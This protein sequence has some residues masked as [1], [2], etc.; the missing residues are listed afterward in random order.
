MKMK[1]ALIWILLIFI[2]VA[3][4]SC[5]SYPEAEQLLAAK[6]DSLPEIVDYNLHVRPILSDKCFN[7][8]GP[9][10]NKQEGGLALHIFELATKEIK[11]HKAISPGNLVQSEAIKRILSNDSEL[12]MPLSGSNLSLTDLE[13]ATLI[14]WIDQGAKY[15]PHWAFI[16][17]LPIS[18]PEVKNKSWVINPIDNFIL[19]KLEKELIQPS[20]QANKEKLA[21]RVS[22]DITGLP[23]TI[24][25]LDSFLQ[26]NSAHS[27]RNYVE[28]LLKSPQYGER[29]ANEWLDVARYAD[30]HGYQDDGESEMW[31]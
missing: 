6:K 30:S 13:K 4:C 17:P 9:D 10:K 26:D 3:V 20:P 15:K 23:P 5:S 8:H 14:K 16:K 25:Q 18:V 7:C 2:A 21:R 27:Y 1:N 11:G 29:M 28:K 19:A 22:I 24:A 12:K 31:P